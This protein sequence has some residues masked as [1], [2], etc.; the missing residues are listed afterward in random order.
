CDPDEWT[1]S[2]NGAQE[3]ISALEVFNGNLYAGQGSDAGDG[4][5]LVCNPEF[6]TSA[7]SDSTICDPDEWTISF[8]GAQE[9]IFSLG[10]FNGKL[11]A[12]QGS[13]AGD[14]DVFVCDP[15]R[16]TTGNPSFNSTP[17]TLICDPDE[18]T[19]SFNGAQETIYALNIF[20]NKLY[21]GSGTS[22]GNISDDILVFG[23][24]NTDV[25]NSTTRS[26]NANQ[27]YHLTGVYNGSYMLLYVNGILENSKAVP[28]LIEQNITNLFV[29]YDPAYGYFN[30]TID[31]VA[32][33]NRTLSAKEIKN[34]YNLNNRRYYWKA[35]ATDL[36]GNINN[37]AIQ[38]F[39][40]TLPP[41]NANTL[42]T[43]GTP[44]RS[45]DNLNCSFTF[46]DP[47]PDDAGVGT[48][49]W[50]NLSREHF[51]T[52]ITISAPGSSTVV[53]YQ[54]TYNNTNN[55]TSGENWTCAAR[56]NDGVINSGLWVNYSILV[57]DTNLSYNATPFIIPNPLFTANNFNATS[58]VA[59]PEGDLMTVE[60]VFWNGT[61]E[62]FR[63]NI[64]SLSNNSLAS[65]T[66]T[67]NATNIFTKGEN[68]TAAFKVFDGNRS[69]SWVNASLLI[70][71]VSQVSPSNNTFL[72]TKFLNLTYNLTVEGGT[73][74]N[75]TLYLDGPLNLNQTDTTISEDINQTFNLTFQDKTFT[76][77]ASCTSSNN[78][79]GNT[80]IKVFTVDTTVPNLTLNSPLNATTTTNI[81]VTLN[82]TTADTLSNITKLI[83][84]AGNSTN[85]NYNNLLYIN[86]SI[87]NSTQN[88]TYNFTALPIKPDG[89]GG[90][91]LLHHYDNASSL[92]NDTHTLDYSNQVK[93]LNNGTYIR[94]NATQQSLGN[95]AYGKFGNSFLFNGINNF[96]NV[97][98]SASLQI[99]QN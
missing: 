60:I 49:I 3:R 59:D 64:T 97:N 4:D 47:N 28:M 21:Q 83:I 81:S 35:N 61:R 27:W 41:D 65:Y 82:I 25:I 33:Y 69:S 26:W 10:V 98:N 73:P 31:E 74:S 44:T 87:Q 30:G 19:I 9:H 18:W 93:A 43:P 50:Y 23:Y 13:G 54:L 95:S 88:I 99:V 5:V 67:N 55:F 76:W 20:N 70:S 91:V 45:T 53:S 38:E 22:T 46:I 94:W 15:S 78:T 8:N 68:W 66:L 57:S 14:G 48:I 92:E 71:E 29:G 79:V 84:Y 86:L 34:L 56:T 77:F 62:H 39:N 80:S 12:G 1:I 52:N 11:Y 89:T 36:A 6:N 72:N 51:R 2:F 32:I 24:N 17:H 96:V 40:I 85:L 42:I 63:R 90:L 75:C 37:T 7:F 58:V 16:N